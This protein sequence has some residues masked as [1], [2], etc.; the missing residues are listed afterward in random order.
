MFKGAGIYWENVNVLLY[1]EMYTKIFC[2][3]GSVESREKLRKDL[4][5][6]C[7]RSET[8][9]MRFNTD[10]CKV[11]LIGVQNLAEV[12]FMEGWAAI[13]STRQSSTRTHELTLKH[14]RV[15]G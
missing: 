3:V 13:I 9:Q 1:I 4:R 15:G 12:Y 14:T 2:V 7:E 11:T 10:K 6:L 8:W 5:M